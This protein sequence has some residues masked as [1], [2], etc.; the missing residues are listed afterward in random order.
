MLPEK[1]ALY[2]PPNILVPAGLLKR[3]KVYLG[4]YYFLTGG[5]TFAEGVPNRLK[6][7]V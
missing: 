1:L 6:V 5:Y 7:P 3:P 4:F 2:A